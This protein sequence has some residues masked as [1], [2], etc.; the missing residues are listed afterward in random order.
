MPIPNDRLVAVL[1]TKA[2]ML[3]SGTMTA[4]RTNDSTGAQ[5]AV[6]T[7]EP[8]L[9]NP[10]DSRTSSTTTEFVRIPVPYKMETRYTV[11]L[12]EGDQV[13]HGTTYY[14]VTEVLSDNTPL[15]TRKFKLERIQPATS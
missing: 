7:N 5:D 14:K 3:L 10:D 4:Y 13:L 1:R 9:I 8:C 2:N 12:K 6:Y 15:I 11:F